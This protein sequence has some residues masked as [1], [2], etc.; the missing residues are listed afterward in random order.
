MKYKISWGTKIAILYSSFV[1]MIAV[2]VLKSN[3]QKV[4][5]V[6]ADYYAQEL[7]FQEKID[8]QNNMNAL[9]INLECTGKNKRASL[10]FPKEFAGQITNG[11]LLFYRP[12]NSLLDLSVP[13]KLDSNGIQ[14]IENKNFERGIYQ[15]KLNFKINGTSY[16]REQ[17]FF[18]N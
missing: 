5:L 15:L 10:A 6:S 3:L 11:E 16:F 2:M 4:D 9:N 14:V 17:Q 18:M 12:S 8:G 1:V 13:L 7:K